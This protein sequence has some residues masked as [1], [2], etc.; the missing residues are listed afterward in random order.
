MKDSLDYS[1]LYYRIAI[2]L[3]HNNENDGEWSE[4]LIN[5]VAEKLKKSISK[6]EDKI[7]RDEAFG[8]I[9]E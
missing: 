7:V 8:I 2:I 4:D 1:L 5:E 9:A 6:S 3:M